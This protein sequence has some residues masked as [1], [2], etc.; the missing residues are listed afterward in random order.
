MTPHNILSIVYL[1]Y[2]SYKNRQLFLSS[3]NQS[4]AF[5]ALPTTGNLLADQISSKDSR[6]ENLRVF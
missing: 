4:V 2:F 3:G 5:A 1:S 6:V